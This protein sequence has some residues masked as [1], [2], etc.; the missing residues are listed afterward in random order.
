M[1][2][3]DRVFENGSITQVLGVSGVGKTTF[4][5]MI[6]GLIIP[7]SGKI[8]VNQEVWYDSAA[9]V[10]LSPQLRKVGFVFQDYALFPNM[11]VEKQLQYGTDDNVYVQALLDMGRMKPYVGH[12]PKELSGGQQQRLA[13]LR[14]LSTRPRIVLMDEP[15]SALDKVLRSVLIQELK[16]LIKVAGIT[17]LVVTHDAFA[18]GEFADETFEMF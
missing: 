1:L 2:K 3:V 17:C 14:A 7:G 13:I 12:K 8:V 10:N 18:A 15:F 9:S 5:K 16:V 4:L 6:A 11:T